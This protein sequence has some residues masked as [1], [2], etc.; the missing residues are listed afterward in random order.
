MVSIFMV[1]ISKTTNRYETHDNMVFAPN[2]QSVLGL[3]FLKYDT[4]K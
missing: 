2:N 4:K 1:L 3:C